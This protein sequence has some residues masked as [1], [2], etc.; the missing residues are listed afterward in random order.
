[1]TL[2]TR[3][4][5]KPI[6]SIVV[7]FGSEY[8]KSI[9]SFAG[10]DYRNVMFC[11]LRDYVTGYENPNTGEYLVINSGGQWSRQSTVSIYASQ[12]DYSEQASAYEM[13]R[14]KLLG[15]I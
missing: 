5:M 10:F 1:M 11:A 15:R 12:Q 6:K 2:P 14:S 13:Y 4:D 3:V 7:N 9:I 8:S